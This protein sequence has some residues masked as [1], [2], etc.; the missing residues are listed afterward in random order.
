MPLDPEKFGNFLQGVGAIMSDPEAMAEFKRRLQ[1][2]GKTAALWW[3]D[4]QNFTPELDAKIRAT[5]EKMDA[6]KT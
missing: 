4:Q 1:E 2:G 3:L 6:P 5:I